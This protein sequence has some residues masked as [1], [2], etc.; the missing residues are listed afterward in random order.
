MISNK[1]KSII[2]TMLKLFAK[3]SKS[4]QKNIGAHKIRGL[5]IYLK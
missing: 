2:L 4:R 5:D 1:I 3:G